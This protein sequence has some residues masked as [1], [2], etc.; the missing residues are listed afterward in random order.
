M[1]NFCHAKAQMNETDTEVYLFN[2]TF[3]F[4]PWNIPG[5]PIKC[6]INETA[7]TTVCTDDWLLR[8]QVQ[9]FNENGTLF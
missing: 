7:R 6:Q 2:K 5:S 1:D 8:C 4:W 3:E 9:G